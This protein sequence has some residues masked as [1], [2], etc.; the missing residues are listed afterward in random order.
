MTARLPTRRAASSAAP[1]P[2]LLAAHS[3]PRLL[4]LL[5]PVLRSLGCA[6]H[7]GVGATTPGAA[8]AAG[9][10]LA[11]PGH[12]CWLACHSRQQLPQGASACQGRC[13][14]RGVSRVGSCSTSSSE[15]GPQRC[16]RDN[17]DWAR[18]MQAV[19]AAASTPTLPTS[20][21]GW[22]NNFHKLLGQFGWQPQHTTPSISA[23]VCAEASRP[24]QAAPTAPSL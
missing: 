4:C 8:G 5:P 6:G 10:C 23:V 14:T 15:G 19:R 16:C 9:R 12:C 13:S 17:P 18:W 21:Q 7:G 3:R 20:G 11:Q 24:P 22:P 1:A 2:A